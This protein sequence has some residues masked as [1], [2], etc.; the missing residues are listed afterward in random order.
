MLKCDFYSE[1]TWVEYL[2]WNVYFSPSKADLEGKKS[3]ILWYTLPQWQDVLGE[4]IQAW[5]KIF[6]E[7]NSTFMPVR[8]I[9]GLDRLSQG[10]TMVYASGRVGYLDLLSVLNFL[11]M[12]EAFTT[13]R[14]LFSS[15]LWEKV[16]TLYLNYAKCTGK[17]SNKIHPAYQVIS[18]CREHL[19]VHFKET[20]TKQQM[21]ERCC[22]YFFC[23]NF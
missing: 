9:V 6:I 23:L 20:N 1:L 22:D 13:A 12:A 7:S 18:V 19:A 17:Y 16:N 8:Y 11:T 21:T 2:S 14:A 3:D 10:K 5:N 15:L 4:I